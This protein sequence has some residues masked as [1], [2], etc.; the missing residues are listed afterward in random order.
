MLRPALL[1]P[2]RGFRR[3]GLSTLRLARTP[4]GAELEPATGLSG[5]YPDGTFT[6]WNGAA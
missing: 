2:T 6:R 3:V 4:L 1:L 5:D